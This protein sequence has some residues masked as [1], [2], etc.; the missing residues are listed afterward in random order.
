MRLKLTSPFHGD[1]P[2]LPCANHRSISSLLLLSIEIFLLLAAE[3]GDHLVD[4][5]DDFVEMTAGVHA[6]LGA[7]GSES[8]GLVLLGEGLDLVNG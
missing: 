7:Q 1:L 3:V 8:E 2:A 4:H 5:S 6:E